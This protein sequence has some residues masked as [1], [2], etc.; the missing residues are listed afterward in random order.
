MKWCSKC[1]DLLKKCKAFAEENGG[2]CMNDQYEEQIQFRC[3][4]GH[5][6]KLNHKNARKRWCLDCVKMQ[7]AELKKKCEQ[8]RAQRQK[9]EEEY[10][11]KLFEEARQKV[12]RDSTI[13]SQIPSQHP[14]GPNSIYGN[15]QRS[16]VDYFARMD[17]EI[18]KLAEKYSNEFM[19]RKEL[20]GDICY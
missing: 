4:Q 1:D 5:T 18:Q 16:V 14:Q 12:L 9:E 2:E 3:E 17:F 15:Q 6:W 19:S 10:Q 20:A 11:K 7:K 13:H 8:E